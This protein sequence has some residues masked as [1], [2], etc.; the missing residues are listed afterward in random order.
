MQTLRESRVLEAKEAVV[1]FHTPDF[2]DMADQV[3]KAANLLSESYD[4]SKTIVKGAITWGKFEVGTLSSISAERTTGQHAQLVYSERRVH[5]R[6]GCGLLGI[7]HQSRR[8][9]LPILPV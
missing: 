5:S 8:I 9:S 4:P 3:V 6:T 1:L 7:L 2:A